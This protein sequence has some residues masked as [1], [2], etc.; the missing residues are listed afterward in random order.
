MPR[1]GLGLSDVRLMVSLIRHREL[2]TIT[3]MKYFHRMLYYQ[4]MRYT[5]TAGSGLLR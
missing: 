5:G 3:G 2:R 1:I 4:P